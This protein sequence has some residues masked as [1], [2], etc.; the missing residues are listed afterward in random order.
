[1]RRS[2]RALALATALVVTAAACGGGGG[3]TTGGGSAG[4][5]GAAGS[6]VN[7]GTFRIGL[8][9]DIHQGLDP[10]REYY[11]I[12]WEFLKGLLVRLLLGFNL[13]GPE[14]GGNELVP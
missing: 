8:V 1:M 12:G 14:E 6:F 13:K 5:S 7:G 4:P 9:S 10:Q 3:G 2:M 11:T